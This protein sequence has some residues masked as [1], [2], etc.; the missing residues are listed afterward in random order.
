[1]FGGK[2][3]NSKVWFEFESEKIIDGIFISLNFVFLSLSL[4][5]TWIKIVT[6]N[7]VVFRD[8][9]WHIECFKCNECNCEL[10]SIP[11]LTRNDR[12]YCRGCHANLFAHRCQK[13]SKPITGKCC[14]D[15][16]F[17]I[18]P[19][20]DLFFPFNYSLFVCFCVLCLQ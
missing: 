7:G 4:S 2:I 1:M 16:F 20:I 17:T 11:F 5:P 10:T 18:S 9:P 15:F 3:S 12:P 14:G 13:C 8:E 19:S 6:S